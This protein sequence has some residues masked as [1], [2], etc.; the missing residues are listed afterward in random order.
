MIFTL[1]IY[2]GE[3][4]ITLTYD[5]ANCDKLPTEV[6]MQCAYITI[7]DDD[8]VEKDELTLILDGKDLPPNIELE[9][10]TVIISIKEPGDG[11]R[12]SASF[13]TPLPCV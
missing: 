6:N 12:D 11:K 9:T 13:A 8:L 4:N 2:T 3:E 10:D 1:V 5:P 7:E